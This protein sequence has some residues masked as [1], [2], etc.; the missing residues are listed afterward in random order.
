MC[1]FDSHRWYQIYGR[2]AQ[3]VERRIE[4]AVVPGSSPG[5][6]TINQTASG[7][8]M[9]LAIVGST[10]L[11]DNHEA[12]QII[13]DCIKK[14][15]PTLII[16]GGAK[17]IDSSAVKIAKEMGI[18]FVEYRPKELNWEAGFK[19]RNI[20]IAEE[21]DSLIRIACIEGKTYGSGWTRDRVSRM[22]K[23]TKEFRIHHDGK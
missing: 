19:P 23:P 21:C 18:P 2:L 7:D 4:D 3:L 9:K 20:K 22:N 12:E 16:S 13:R 5:L 10:M 17:G 14:L 15:K 8:N 1:G 11:E 6:S